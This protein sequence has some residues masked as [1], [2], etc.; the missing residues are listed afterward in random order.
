[1]IRQANTTGFR[2]RLRPTFEKLG[3]IDYMTMTLEVDKLDFIKKLRKQVDES[4]LGVFSDVGDAFSSSKNE[5]KGEV[6]HEGFQIKRKRKFFDTNFNFAVAKGQFRQEREQL[7][8]DIELDA[9]NK[10]M[11]IFYIFIIVFYLAFFGVILTLGRDSSMP[12]IVLPFMLLHAG[13]MF[14]IP[15]FIMR[16]SVRRMKYE[17]ERELFF[18]ANK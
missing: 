11:Q 15:F 2:A 5:F 3:L 18:I 9:V 16:R 1:M 7:A 8:I 10:Q 6:D 4:S 14:G 17:L 13:M 12:L